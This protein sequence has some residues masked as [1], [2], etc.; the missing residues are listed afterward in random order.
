MSVHTHLV[1]V[2]SFSIVFLIKSFGKCQATLA[3]LG[4][5]RKSIF[6]FSRETLGRTHGA[7]SGG[8]NDSQGKSATS[9][10][11]EVR[12]ERASKW[13][14]IIC[15]KKYNT[16]LPGVAQWVEREPVNQRVAGLIPSQGTCLGCGSGS[17]LGAHKRQP[18]ID[19]YLLF[20]SLSLSLKI[21]K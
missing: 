15:F 20:P 11:N 17:Q 19:V 2:S 5:P 6:V 12:K 9:L 13:D 14:W 1:S 7:H 21:N 16:A 8:S 18:H 4:K 10:W 3:C